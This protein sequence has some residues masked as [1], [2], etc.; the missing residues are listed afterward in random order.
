[1]NAFNLQTDKQ[2]VLQR[3]WRRNRRVTSTFLTLLF[4]D[5]WLILLD[6]FLKRPRKVV[7]FFYQTSYLNFADLKMILADIWTLAGSGQC[8]QTQ[9]NNFLL[10][11]RTRIL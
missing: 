2:N 3:R 10:E 6:F 8:F 4:A 1:M 5:F 7:F 9:N 11:T